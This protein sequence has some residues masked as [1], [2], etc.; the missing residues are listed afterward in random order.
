MTLN[1]VSKLKLFSRFLLICYTVL[2]HVL[3][4]VLLYYD[5][6][7]H[8]FPMYTFATHTFICFILYQQSEK[9]GDCSISFY[10]V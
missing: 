7:F 4:V 1:L 5:L 8:P 9:F 2:H 3:Y 10:L 6:H